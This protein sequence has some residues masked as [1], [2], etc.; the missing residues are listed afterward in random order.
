MTTQANPVW[1]VTGCSSGLGKALATMLV[2]DTTHRVAITALDMADLTSLAAEAP[3]R[4]LALTL[5]IT[6]RASAAAAITQVTARFGRLDVLVNNAGV[7]QI[8]AIEELSEDEIARAMGVNFFGTLNMLRATLPQMRAQRGGRI[9]TLTSMGGFRG[10]PAIG[11]YNASKFALEG[12]HEALAGE[13]APLG[14]AVTMVEPGLFR[15]GFRGGGGMLLARNIIA[16]YAAT[17]GQMRAAVA[18]DYPASAAQ[19]TQIAAAILAVGEM[20]GQ[21]PLRLQLGSDA[22][23][24]TREKLDTM[25]RE[26]TRWESVADLASQGGEGMA[27]SYRAAI[28]AVVAKGDLQ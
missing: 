7:G 25:A 18:R 23:A 16:D 28:A 14:I 1:L 15:S 19:P 21:P 5:D 2:R 9:L 8:G 6:D 17:S 20:A 11:I 4:V 10:R 12:A 26:V 22:V 27:D 3:D 24:A 13:V